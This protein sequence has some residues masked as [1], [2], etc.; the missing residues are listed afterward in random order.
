MMDA[1]PPQYFADVYERLVGAPSAAPADRERRLSD[2]T[3]ADLSLES[4]SPAFRV[5]TLKIG[6]RNTNSFEFEMR[7]DATQL[8]TRWGELFGRANAFL[9]EHGPASCPGLEAAVDTAVVAVAPRARIRLRR[10]S[11]YGRFITSTHSRIIAE[12]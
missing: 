3:E 1:A 9:A 5:F 8:D 11:T 2:V 10:V 7:G 4:T 6:G 12:K